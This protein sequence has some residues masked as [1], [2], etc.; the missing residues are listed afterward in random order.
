MMA[1][2]NRVPPTRRTSF[3]H[4][5]MRLV[6]RSRRGPRK[7]FHKMWDIRTI[8]RLRSLAQGRWRSVGPHYQRCI[9]QVERDT[10]GAVLRPYQAPRL[11]RA[12][13]IDIVS[14]GDVGEDDE[15]GTSKRSHPQSAPPAQGHTSAGDDRR[16]QPGLQLNSAS[17]LTAVKNAR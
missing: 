16:R 12:Q 4:K 1:T 6:C 3:A 13:A 15:E 5:N 8:K 11:C 7:A 17:N 14:R 10:C 2:T 9:P